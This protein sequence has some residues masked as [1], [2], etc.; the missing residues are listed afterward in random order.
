MWRT[1]DSYVTL[2]LHFAVAVAGDTLVDT[3]VLLLHVRNYQLVEACVRMTLDNL[4]PL[5]GHSDQPIVLVT[6][7][8][9]DALLFFSE[10]VYNAECTQKI[11]E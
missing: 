7:I 3:D 6:K 11:K 4:Y 10:W 9:N 1:R 8:Y 5:V 2:T